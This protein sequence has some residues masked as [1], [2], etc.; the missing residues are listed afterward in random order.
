MLYY[1]SSKKT[2]NNCVYSIDM[3]RI[4]FELNEKFNE[5]FNEFINN[6]DFGEGCSLNRFIS[7][8]G[9]G[10]H[11]LYN[12][13]IEENQKKCSFTIGTG[14]LCKKSNENKGFIEFNPNKCF[15]I[16]KFQN[17]LDK[18][19]KFCFS[20]KIKRYDLAIDIP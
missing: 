11:Y 19:R 7:K 4:N 8:S 14:L 18:F 5:S 1:W 17:I 6:F 3:I 13:T 2:K 16:N 20:W 15:E 10:Y 12:L 9:L